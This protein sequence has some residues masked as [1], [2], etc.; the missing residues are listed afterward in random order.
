MPEDLIEAVSETNSYNNKIQAV[1]FNNDQAIVQDNH[2]NN[3]NKN[4]HTHINHTNNPEDEIHDELYSSPQL[5]GMKPNKIVDQEY[6]VLLP[7]RPSKSTSLSVKHNE[8][9]Y[10]ST[11]LHGLFLMYLY[12][13]IITI[14]CLHL[15]L[16]VYINKNISYYLYEGIST[17][18]HLLVSLP[19]SLWNGIL[20]P[21]LFTSLQSKFLRNESI[22]SSLLTSL[23]SL[24]VV[25]NW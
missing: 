6:K 12:E 5:S 19:V 17:V 16:T 8:T 2:S 24:L 14:L 13:A 7:V 25:R 4:G 15:S 22:R 10:T 3:H 21:S 11:S 23:P 1:H 20:R 18:A 9:T